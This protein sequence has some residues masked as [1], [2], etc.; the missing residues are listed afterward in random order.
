[1]KLRQSWNEG[2]NWANNEGIKTVACDERQI[3]AI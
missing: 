3:F 1:M 2:R